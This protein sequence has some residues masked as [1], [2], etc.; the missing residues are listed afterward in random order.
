MLLTSLTHAR[1]VQF[2]TVK[3]PSQVALA[4]VQGLASSVLA[5]LSAQ[6]IYTHASDL[7]EAIWEHQGAGQSGLYCDCSK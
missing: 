6:C 2:W 7:Y 1:S 3:E 5:N 4:F